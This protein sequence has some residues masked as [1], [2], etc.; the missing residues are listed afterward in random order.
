MKL[1][2]MLIWLLTNLIVVSSEFINHQIGI[3]SQGSRSQGNGRSQGIILNSN[4]FIISNQNHLISSINLNNS[5]LSKSSLNN[6]L[7]LRK[8]N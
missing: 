7:E 8:P 4:Y 5:N 6:Y 3:S 2:I 1:R